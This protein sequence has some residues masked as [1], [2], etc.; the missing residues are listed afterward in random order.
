MNPE[1]KTLVSW[2]TGKDS[3]WTLYHVQRDPAFELTG[4]FCTVNKEFN[5][6]AMH[7]VRIA[8][9]EKQARCLGLPVEILEIP[10]PCS[11]TDYERLMADYVARVKARG[12]TRIAFGDLFLEDIRDYRIAKLKGSGIAPV[13][14][15][16][17][18]PTDLLAQE[19][20]DAG[21]KAVITC[22]DPKQLPAEF[23]GRQFDHDFLAALPPGVDPCGERGEFHS[24][25][26]DGPM[27]ASAIDIVVGEIVHRDGFVFADVLPMAVA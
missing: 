4:I 3:A 14:P 23:V 16:W 13:F 21:V 5:R 12:V 10:Y 15:L 9:L 26:Y 25:V 27:F 17:G 19:M 11:N 2:S 24:F 18:K 8:L 7:A 1:G 22:V 6:T 20:I